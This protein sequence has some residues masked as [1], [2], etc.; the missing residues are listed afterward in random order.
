MA[1]REHIVSDE[2]EIGDRGSEEGE[3]DLIAPRLSERHAHLVPGGDLDLVIEREAHDGEQ[4]QHHA[5]S[6]A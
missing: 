2:R 3:R 6:H 4:H 1:E 5:R